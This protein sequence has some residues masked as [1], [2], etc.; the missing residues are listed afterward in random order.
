MLQS[1][2]GTLGAVVNFLEGEI[3]A[4]PLSRP[5]PPSQGV[6]VYWNDLDATF[7]QDLMRGISPKSD[8]SPANWAVHLANK[9]KYHWKTLSGTSPGNLF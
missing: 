8:V 5:A 3:V 7:V 2:R 4:L 9:I 6:L 1:G